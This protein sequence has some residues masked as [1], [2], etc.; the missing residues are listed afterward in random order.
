MSQSSLKDINL[1]C[2]K[3]VH[4]LTRKYQ[5]LI[6]VDLRLSGDF[7]NECDEQAKSLSQ[8]LRVRAHLYYWEAR[9]YPLSYNNILNVI[10]QHNLTDSQTE[11]GII[12]NRVFLR[13]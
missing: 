1:V 8:Y 12:Q 6:R 13:F 10:L 5:D 2:V 11:I 4:S 7:S 9:S 3:K